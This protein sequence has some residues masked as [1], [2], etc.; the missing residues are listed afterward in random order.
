MER[1]VVKIIYLRY[2]IIVPTNAYNYIE[3]TFTYIIHFRA[4][5]IN[6]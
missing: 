1:S 6:L 4:L 2:K 5:T 3:F